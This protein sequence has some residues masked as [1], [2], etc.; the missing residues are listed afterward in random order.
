MESSRIYLLENSRARPTKVTRDQKIRVVSPHLTMESTVPTEAIIIPQEKTLVEGFVEVVIWKYCPA[1]VDITRALI[2]LETPEW[3]QKIINL[4]SSCALISLRVCLSR[5]GE[6]RLGRAKNR[7]I[8]NK[9]PVS[10]LFTVRF[11]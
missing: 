8:E 3:C 11:V 4:F 7:K 9:Q 2:N 5:E 1:V 6:S 10:F